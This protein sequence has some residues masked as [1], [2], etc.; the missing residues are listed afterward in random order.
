M[1]SRYQRAYVDF[2]EDELV[3]NGYDWRK[4]LV[5]Y[6]V[7]GKE[8]LINNLV[9]GRE[10]KKG[11]PPIPFPAYPYIKC[12]YLPSVVGHPLIHLGYAYELSSR[13]LAMEALAMAATSYNHLHKY[14]DD[15]SYTTPSPPNNPSKSPL[16][17]LCRLQKD[18]RFDGVLRDPG[19]DNLQPL[20]RDHEA[21]MLEYWNAW[22]I[23]SDPTQDFQ[24][25]QR[26]AA[27]LLV[28][29]RKAGGAP[30]DFFLVHVL[31]TSHAVR[32]LLPLLPAKYHI[33]LVR[34]WWLLT[35]SVYIAQLRPEILLRSV[36]DYDL[37]GRGWGWMDGQAVGGK[38]ALDAHYVKGLRA[39]KTAAK[40]WGDE[41]RFY[42]KAAVRFGDEFDGWGGFGLS[43]REGAQPSDDKYA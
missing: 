31:T 14:L 42:L 17:L 21:L 5:T 28:A 24:A 7:Q 11:A 13:D 25:S 29:S 39:L 4:V 40:T 15:P 9:S 33:P 38:Y 12:S 19:P 43:A 34:Q 20:F 32:I 1:Q 10:L 35:L 22:Q 2:F 18:N 26:A 27:A 3:L 23:S 37:K 36:G 30:Y 16:E 41:D 6:L 8:P